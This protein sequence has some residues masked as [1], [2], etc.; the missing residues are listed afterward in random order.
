MQPDLLSRA[1]AVVDAS[2]REIYP[3]TFFK[4]CMYASLGI[5]ALLEDEGITAHMVGGDFICVV[6]STDA[7][8]LASQ[9]F[10]SPVAG[11]PSHFWV[12]AQG[13]LID[14]GPMYLPVKSSYPA[15]PLPVFRLKLAAGAPKFCKYR[16]HNRYPPD[17]V[18]VAPKMQQRIEEF[19]AHCRAR[20]RLASQQTSLETWE[21]TGP[22][23]LIDAARRGDLWA[24]AAFKYLAKSMK[25]EF[26]DG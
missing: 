1:L 5:V 22:S 20:M 6:V 11:T 15:A 16:E 4:R 13:E 26:P 25:A 18:L 7:K 14:L 10:K 24:G 9:G 3:D 19:V 17:V 23:S 2:L 12:E 21:M 8:Q